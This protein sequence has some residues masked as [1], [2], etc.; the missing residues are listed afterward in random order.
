MDL[1]NK[2][3]KF[4]NIGMTIS[5]LNMAYCGIYFAI[6]IG[7]IIE[8]LFVAL[9]SGGTGSGWFLFVVPIYLLLYCCTFIPDSICLIFSILYKIKKKFIFLI[10]ILIFAVIGTLIMNSFLTDDF[11]LVLCVYLSI[12]MICLS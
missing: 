3:V 11:F 4:S 10:I 9:A 6:T 2:D 7:M 12:F 1:N 5:I 8:N